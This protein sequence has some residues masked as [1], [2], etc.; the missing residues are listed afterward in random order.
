[1]AIILLYWPN[2]K[3]FFYDFAENIYTRLLEKR[4][5]NM[6]WKTKDMVN[7][8]IPRSNVINDQSLGLIHNAMI[9]RYQNSSD[10]S[11]SLY[12]QP[13]QPLSSES[14]QP[15][16]MKAPEEVLRTKGLEMFYNN[17]LPMLKQLLDEVQMKHLR[18]DS[19]LSLI[20]GISYWAM[21]MP[22]DASFFLK[23]ALDN[24][25]ITPDDHAHALWT[26]LYLDNLLGKTNV[27]QYN[28]QIR[29][30]LQ[31]VSA[32]DEARCLN[33]ELAI[34]RNE[35]D[36]LGSGKLINLFDLANQ[37]WTFN[38]RISQANLSTR[39]KINYYLQN[40]TNL[41]A[42]AIYTDSFFRRRFVFSKNNGEV[43]DP[44]LMLEFDSLMVKLTDQ[45]DRVFPWIKPLARNFVSSV[46]VAQCFEAQVSV[47]LHLDLNALRLPLKEFDFLAKDHIRRICL[48]TEFAKEAQHIFW[49]HNM[50]LSAHNMTLMLMEL[51]EFATH[52]NLIVDV[53]IDATRKQAD[54]L[55]QKLGIG[56]W[57]LQARTVIEDY[58]VRFRSSE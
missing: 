8:H 57:G 54:W 18:E 11:P 6:T 38:D 16:S 9:L 5:G 27:Q 31:D 37:F 42:L 25:T 39:I 26:K 33:Y 24:P 47:W 44:G 50:Y 43:I 56:Q 10:R 29:E 30:L 52:S 34:A 36:L 15:T 49:E 19:H 20:A 58:R 40:I 32:S 13:S 22:V 17:D 51:A 7:I 2:A 14:R 28:Q 1:M 45:M 53:D 12:P 3:A 46:M 48:H 23:K 55:T 35:I 41:G 21:G 4:D